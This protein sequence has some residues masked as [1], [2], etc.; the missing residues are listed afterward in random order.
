MDI[1]MTRS[2]QTK[3]SGTS[4][5][6]QSA[7]MEMIERTT[8]AHAAD[9]ARAGRYKEAEAALREGLRDRE[10]SEA[11]LDLL[12]RIHAQQGHWKEAKAAW[13]QA[14]KINPASEQYE[15]GLRRIAQMKLW[16]GFPRVLIPAVAVL[17][18]LLGCLAGGWLLFF[19]AHVPAAIPATATLTPIPTQTAQ[20]TATATPIPSLTPTQTPLPSATATL[21]LSATPTLLTCKVITGI[22]NGSLNV[23][24]GPDVNFPS[25]G[26]LAEGEQVT[27]L[28]N[29]DFQ[30]TTGWLYIIREPDLKGWI[31]SAYCK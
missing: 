2:G 26:H 9:L 27:I 17:L 10:A 18:I 29:S 7:L 24:S 16:L 15:A 4:G 11:I 25:V 20:P 14:L 19:P 6:D 13:T 21:E 30:K 28:G 5:E 8:L 23:R 12:A 1:K 3:P 31:N 22:V